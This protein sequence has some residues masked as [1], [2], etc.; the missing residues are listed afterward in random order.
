M[1]YKRLYPEKRYCLYCGKDISDKKLS[2][3]IYGSP[4]CE[5]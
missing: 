3:I 2:A 5:K 4:E 1:L